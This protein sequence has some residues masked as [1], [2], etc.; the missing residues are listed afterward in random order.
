LRHSRR[1]RILRPSFESRESITLSSRLPHFAQYIVSNGRDRL[2]LTQPVG[3]SIGKHPR[4]AMRIKCHERMPGFTGTG[5]DAVPSPTR[6]CP[7]REQFRLDRK[8]SWIR[9][10]VPILRR[11]E[12]SL[13]RLNSIRGRLYST[14]PYCQETISSGGSLD[15]SLRSLPSYPLPPRLPSFAMAKDTA[16]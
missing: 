15:F 16:E 5:N 2:R 11:P 1:R 3:E 13:G 14:Y 8:N 12:D 6:G 7:A 9:S 4:P 10:S